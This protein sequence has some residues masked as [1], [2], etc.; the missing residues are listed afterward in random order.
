MEA[1]R[2]RDRSSVVS[3]RARRVVVRPRRSVRVERTPIVR[4]NKINNSLLNMPERRMTFSDALGEVY[5]RLAI[6][7]FQPWSMVMYL[8]AVVM[9]VSYIVEPAGTD[10]LSSFAA[11]LKD[12]YPVISK[13]IVDNLIKVMGAMWFLAAIV[14]VRDRIKVQI[15][16]ICVFWLFFFPEPTIYDPILQ[17]LGLLVVLTTKH[18]KTRILVMVVVGFYYF[19]TI[20]AKNSLPSPGLRER[21]AFTPKN[22]SLHG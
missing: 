3:T 20:K 14:T 1:L 21:H 4:N 13:F 22:F 16:M 11:S 9:A 8:M 17:S 15:V 6:A 18:V 5:E 2:R 7:I 10:V 19:M 12:K